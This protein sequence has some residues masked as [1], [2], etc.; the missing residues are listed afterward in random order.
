MIPARLRRVSH[1]QPPER[2]IEDS[3]TGA[4]LDAIELGVLSH[5]RIAAR[6]YSVAVENGALTW[7]NLEQ[8]HGRAIQAPHSA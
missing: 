8:Q 3:P 7:R 4:V 1:E 5:T 6:V 2:N